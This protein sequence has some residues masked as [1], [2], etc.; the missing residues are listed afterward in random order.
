MAATSELR[1]D[2]MAE[3]RGK[4]APRP[5]RTLQCDTQMEPKSNCI[6]TP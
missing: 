1:L 3:S 2:A 6:R 4:Y 5:G